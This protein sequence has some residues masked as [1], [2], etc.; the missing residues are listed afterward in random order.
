MSVNRDSVFEIEKWETINGGK[1]WN[2]QAV[3]QGSSKNNI[4]P[5]AVRGAGE[6]NPIQFMWMQNTRYLHY[7]YP[8]LLKRRYQMPFEYRF[9]S[10][11][12]MN[13][14][15]PEIPDPLSE[16]GIVNLMRQ[17]ADWQLSNPL[18][19]DDFKKKQLDWLYGAF[20]TGLMRLYQTTGECRY[21]EE[22][23]NVGDQVG[24]GIA[25]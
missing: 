15:S 3:T 24:L 22:M 9:K 6:G 20:S 13:L 18:P 25:G 19:G 1:T 23:I 12:K 11:L 5:V 16:A 8:S 14:V 17:V 2:I 10:A 4:R 21:A 7:A